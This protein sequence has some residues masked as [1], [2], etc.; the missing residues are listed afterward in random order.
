MPPV[1]PTARPVTELACSL[2]RD[3]T[4]FVTSASR[5]AW[6]IGVASFRRAGP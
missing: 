5:P 6:Y 3:A 2:A 1:T 4:A